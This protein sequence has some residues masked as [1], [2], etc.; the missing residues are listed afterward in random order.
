MAQG[1][2]KIKAVFAAKKA[3]GKTVFVPFVTAGYPSDLETVGILL[4]LEEGGADII[5]VG[6][7]HTDP[8]ADGPTIQQANNVALAGGVTT[9]KCLDYIKEARE[10]GLKAPVILMGYYNPIHQ[11]GEEKFVKAAKEAGADGFIVVDLPWDEGEIF[12]KHCTTHGLSFVPLIAQTTQEERLKQFGQIADSFVYCISLLGVTGV[13]NQISNDLPSFIE[14]VRK[15]VNTPLAVGF[16]ISTKEHFDRVAKLGEGVVVGSMLTKKIGESEIGTR[17]DIA[18]EVAQYFSAPVQATPDEERAAHTTEVERKI[19]KLTL[20]AKF[21]QFGGRYAPETLI[22]ALEELESTWAKLKTDVDFQKEV[23]S[24]YNFIGRPTPL[25]YAERMTKECGG[26]NIWFKREDLAHTG[27]HK[28]NNAIGQALLAK[29]LNK[30]RIIAETGAGQHGVA[31]AT[32]CAKLGLECVIYM[33]AED[34][35]RQSLNVFKMKLLGATV[36]PVVS[37][38]KTLKDAVNEAMRDWVTNVRNTHYIVGSAIG[39]HPFPTIVRDFQSVIGSEARQQF[40]DKM[41]KLPDV[42]MACVGGGSNSIGMFHPF[43]ND[44]NVQLIGVEAGGHGIASDDHCATLI[45]GTPGILHGTCTYVLQDKDGQIKG[46]HSISAGLD[47]PAV[48]PEHAH[49]KDSGRAQYVAVDDKQ[50]LEGFKMLCSHEGIIPALETS[51][52]IYYA[53][54]L[55]QSMNKGENI[56]VCMS[57]RGDKDMNTVAKALGVQLS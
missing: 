13:K 42:V 7:P 46:T 10:R 34:I 1:I 33:G 20:P 12:R 9:Q 16:G 43:I 52:A 57:G 6:I 50:A 21:G 18:K 2:E 11:Y 25:Y 47:Y 31:T 28:I 29:R 37:G 40:R 45:K 53:A 39:P 44:N 15:H 22:A 14:K 30:T 49:L 23:K 51:H 17:A 19:E 32:V 38:S 36:V 35:E 27:A 54:Q 4:A 26:A 55:A 48:G 8:L 56:L 24:Y 3:E 41:G 5:E